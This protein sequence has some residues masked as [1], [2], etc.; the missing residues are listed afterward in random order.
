MTEANALIE[1]YK[2]APVPPNVSRLSVLLQG[3]FASNAVEIAQII[4]DDPI[5]SARLIRIATNPKRRDEEP[6]EIEAAVMRLGVGSILVLVMGE[7]LINAVLRAFSTMLGVALEPL[8]SEGR[9]L[10]QFVGKI[11]FAGK[12]NGHVFLRI[13]VSVGPWFVTH[14]LGQ[15]YAAT[16]E[17]LVPDVV[18]EMLNIVCGNF[19]SNLCDAGLTCKLFPPTVQVS[20]GFELEWSEEEKKQRIGMTTEGLPFFCDLVITPIATT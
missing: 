7:L 12:A 20:E 11:Q 10:K 13:P 1:K 16:A 15:E 17:E 6:M 4:K 2:L 5:L 3:R 18:G 14:A 8:D 19:K 9:E